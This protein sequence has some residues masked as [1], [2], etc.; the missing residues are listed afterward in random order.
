MKTMNKD[1]NQ[2]KFGFGTDE[3]LPAT[4]LHD[5]VERRNIRCEKPSVGG[6]VRNV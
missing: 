1:D 2:I 4:R 3:D 5:Q 6:E